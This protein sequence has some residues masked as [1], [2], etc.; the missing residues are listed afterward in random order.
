MT[1][2]KDN[3]TQTCGISFILFLHFLSYLLYEQLGSDTLVMHF[4]ITRS[5]TSLS[6][7]L[8]KPIL[9]SII[10]SY[11][12]SSVYLLFSFLQYTFQLLISLPLSIPS[13][14]PTQTIWIYFLSY[15]LLLK[16]LRITTSSY[17]LISYFVFSIHS[18][19]PL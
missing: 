15:Y 3:Q 4:Y 11:I 7:T 18:T 1:E 14:K 19:Y 5:P 8:A 6:L 10:S 16:P 12:L 2:E 9:L 17:V 13:F